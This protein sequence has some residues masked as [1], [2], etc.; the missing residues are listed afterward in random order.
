MK[1]I[2][3]ILPIVALMFAPSCEEK[4]PT[5][6][7]EDRV[8]IFLLTGLPT[9]PD[10]T[11]YFTFVFETPETTQHIIY[12]R[13]NTE[14]MIRDY[15]RAVTLGQM[16]SGG[17]N[18]AVPGVHY[19]AFDDPQVKDLYVI[20]AG[21]QTTL[22]PI[23]LLRD[24][25]LKESTKTLRIEIRPNEH[26]QRSAT[27]GWSHRQLVF[28][29]RLYKPRAWDEPG[30][31]TTYFGVYGQAKH[32]FMI[33]VGEQPF[34]DNWFNNNFVWNTAEELWKARDASHMNLLSNWLQLRLTE[35]NL[36]EGDDLKEAD[37]T[38]VTFSNQP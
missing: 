20:P 23:V 4:I 9:Q 14:G 34:N 37:G 38:V 35:R 21:A 8:N 16:S 15:P 26:F 31:V 3:Y 32:L 1:K 6:S 12:V 30:E 11:Q 33:T 17:D 29:D 10:T 7:G 36:R 18:D 13:I 5:W 28:S 24:P 19:V 22:F 2:M 27:R 25:S